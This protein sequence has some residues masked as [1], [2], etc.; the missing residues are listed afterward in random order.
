[1]N[2]TRNL[3]LIRTLTKVVTLSLDALKNLKPS[4]EKN[5]DR[6]SR[7][8][9]IRVILQIVLQILMIGTS[10]LVTIDNDG[11]KIKGGTPNERTQQNEND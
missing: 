10:I 8:K 5:S 3:L 9:L 6:M 2:K 4:K 7:L 11:S 1:M